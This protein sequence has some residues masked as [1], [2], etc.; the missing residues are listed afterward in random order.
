M[1][2]TYNDN[3]ELIEHLQK[4]KEDAYLHLVTSFHKPLFI[5]ALS[6]TNDRDSSEDIIQNVFLKT[7]EYRKNLNPKYSIKS[8]LYKTT[9]NEFINQYH[10]NRT[11]STL[12]LV[13]SESLNELIDDSNSELL[14]QKIAFVN[15]NIDRLPNKCKKI[16]L[17]SKKEGLTNMEI[18]EYMDI[19][20][21]TVEGHLVKAYRFLRERAANKL[22]TILVLLFGSNNPSFICR[23]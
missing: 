5:Y 2:Y 19:S 4:G 16:F 21:K 17:L 11:T 10:K 15:E 7:W 20:I 23:K 8:F 1:P 9:Y 6:L 22:K 13:Y 12:E 14:K 18:A 3:T